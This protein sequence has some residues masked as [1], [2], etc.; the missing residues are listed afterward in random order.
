MKISPVDH[1]AKTLDGI[2]AFMY[3]AYCGSNCFSEIILELLG[4][5]A[6]KMP[7]PRSK[8]LA[9]IFLFVRIFTGREKSWDISQTQDPG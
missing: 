3:P 8:Q 9:S 5:S 6:S 4:S 7:R 1:A 2:G